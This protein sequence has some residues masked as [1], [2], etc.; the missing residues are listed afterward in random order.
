[1]AYTIKVWVKQSHLGFMRNNRE[2]QR[3]A[4]RCKFKIWNDDIEDSVVYTRDISDGGV[5]LVMDPGEQ[6]IP[7]V[8]T[9]LLGQ[10]QDMM[11]DAPV[12]TLE[13]VRIA[14]E[15]IGLRFITDTK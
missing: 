14:D 5:F 7:P 4:L 10:V 6:S 8:G 13:V 9:V 15:G 2:H 11:A 3:T 12:V 1:M